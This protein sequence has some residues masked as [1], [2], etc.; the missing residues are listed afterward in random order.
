MEAGGW[1]KTS[2]LIVFCALPSVQ[3][4]R[5][6]TFCLTRL[7]VPLPPS[8]GDTFVPP[9]ICCLHP[10]GRWAEQQ[11]I[12]IGGEYET[13]CSAQGPPPGNRWPRVWG[14]ACWTWQTERRRE[15]A[16]QISCTSTFSSSPRV[17]AAFER[18]P[19]AVLLL[20]RRRFSFY[21]FS[22]KG[23]F[24]KSHHIALGN[25]FRTS[26]RLEQRNLWIS[27]QG[28]FCPL[29]S[30]TV[31]F[32][33]PLSTGLS[34]LH[35]SNGHSTGIGWPYPISSWTSHTSQCSFVDL[36]HFSLYDSCIVFMIHVILYTQLISKL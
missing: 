29:R 14:A 8:R 9:A 31:I 7:R 11:K 3:Q 10:A 25:T 34:E 36:Q 1:G 20:L 24:T 17:F 21:A 2:D 5:Y 12:A 4:L 6:S 23:G 15:Q 26:D 28:L 16:A 13:R 18:R 27:G 19:K 30:R 22:R 33:N 35:C 32:S